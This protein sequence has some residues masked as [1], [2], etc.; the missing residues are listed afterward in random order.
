[1]SD[2]II[3]RAA[4]ASYHTL[5]AITADI[6]PGAPFKTWEE[7]PEEQRNTQRWAMRAALRA[8]KDADE[9]IVAA[10]REAASACSHDFYYETAWR[11]AI[12][13]ILAEDDG[14]Q[15]SSASNERPKGT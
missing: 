15:D 1:M 3:E 4:K 14:S 12:D 10:M 9:V 5:T 11:M 8:I 2:S 13:A 7:L 6:R